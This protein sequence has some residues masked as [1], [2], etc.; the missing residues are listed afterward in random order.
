MIAIPEV[1]PLACLPFPVT[2]C[3]CQR[4]HG[5]SPEQFQHCSTAVQYLRDSLCGLTTGGHAH[6]GS[7]LVY[8]SDTKHVVRTLGIPG[9]ISAIL[10][11][12]RETRQC[13]KRFT[14]KQVVPN[15]YIILVYVSATRN[16]AL[17]LPFSLYAINI[18]LILMEIN[19][20]FLLI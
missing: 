9:L 13:K 1:P 7:L 15:F 12:C 11:I 5:I 14:F 17:R 19:F 18:Y 6:C 10:E 16:F 20:G 8:W 2:E 4:R 3:H